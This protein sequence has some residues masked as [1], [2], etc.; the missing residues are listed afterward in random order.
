MSSDASMNNLPILEAPTTDE[1]EDIG[2]TPL[3]RPG[4]PLIIGNKPRLR[5]HEILVPPSTGKDDFQTEWRLSPSSPDLLDGNIFSPRTL[6]RSKTLPGPVVTAVTRIKF[7]ETMVEE[8][9]FEPEKLFRLRRWVLSIVVGAFA[10]ETQKL[11][12]ETCCSGF[13]SGTWSHRGVSISLADLVSR[14]EREHVCAEFWVSH[15]PSLI[16]LKRVLVIPRLCPVRPR[17][18]DT[19]LP[20]SRDRSHQRRYPS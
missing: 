4:T 7:E 10:P 15:R 12:D 14:R 17:V 16:N 8:L 9:V 3:T 1:E 13:R 2:L 6:T 18:T 19:F 20:Y 11:G 5:P